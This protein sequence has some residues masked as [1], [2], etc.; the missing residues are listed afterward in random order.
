M[1]HERVLIG[2]NLN[3]SYLIHK[4]FCEGVKKDSRTLKGLQKD[5]RKTLGPFHFLILEDLTCLISTILRLMDVFSVAV[6][7]NV[8]LLVHLLT[9]F[10]Y[11][12]E[13][14]PYIFLY[15][16]HTI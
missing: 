16:N 12:F 3:D 7:N 8:C 10:I 11:I 2:L 5:S 6:A 13:S 1:I 9:C 4:T 15:L 14:F